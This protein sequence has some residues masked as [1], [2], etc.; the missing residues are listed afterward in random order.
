MAKAPKTSPFGDFFRNL[1]A[2]TPKEQLREVAV[3]SLI[4]EALSKA[5]SGAADDDG[6]VRVLDQEIG[7]MSLKVPPEGQILTGPQQA[8][9]GA[10]AE[11]MV[12]EYSNPD[13][14]QDLVATYEALS[15]ELG[16]M[17]GYMKSMA[18]ATK[19]TQ[20]ALLALLKKADEE[21]EE[22]E[23]K[24]NEE[25]GEGK[26]LAASILKD[27]ISKAEEEEEEEEGDGEEEEEEESAKSIPA[28]RRLA[29]ADA[30][31]EAARK[32][33]GTTLKKGSATALRRA[34]A[35]A[36]L[37]AWVIAKT[38][39]AEATGEEA[40]RPAFKA[41]RKSAEA[42][43]E[44]AFLRG[45]KLAAFPPKKKDEE[46]ESDEA[47]ALDKSALGGSGDPADLGKREPHTNQTRWANGKDEAHPGGV[48]KSAAEEALDKVL[49]GNAVLTSQLQDVMKMVMGQS[50]H[51]TMGVQELPLAKAETPA[52]GDPTLLVK[53]NPQAYVLAKSDAINDAVDSGVF[54]SVADEFSARDIL[55]AYE[56]Y[57][58]GSIELGA[59]Q[60]RVQAAPAV[61]HL[62][63]EIMELRAA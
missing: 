12:R 39:E 14:Q 52:L 45:I 15:R 60:A 28:A 5:E 57:T 6:D 31:L 37:R 56:A 25:E 38:V 44:F 32:A 13:P 55:S 48:M 27:L 30:T 20:D 43:A 34:I 17:R 41:A 53:G 46:K 3:D 29:I 54:T 23:V 7:D 49:K 26:S 47:P 9:S 22:V 50:K 24:V 11:K 58:Q 36:V 21:E 19:A 2:A 61:R 4:R 33:G 40:S 1:I 18:A 35:K 10:G 62:F 42:V 63:P 51:V 8:A 59:V 16:S